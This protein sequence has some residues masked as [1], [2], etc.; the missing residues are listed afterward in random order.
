[1]KAK[2]ITMLGVLTA[3]AVILSF[4]E[5]FLDFS[6]LAPGVKIGLANAVT[7]VLLFYGKRLDA[8][9]VGVCRVILSAVAFGSPVTFMYAFA[10]FILS[11]F[12]MLAVGKLNVS[13]FLVSVAGGIFHNAGQTAAALILYGKAMLAY[14]PV[15]LLFGCISGALIGVLCALLCKNKNIKMLLE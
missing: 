1:M 5:S 8:F 7:V 3:I 12:V 13:P 11:F 10:G 4:L 14:L 15:L 6:F 2:R 9:A